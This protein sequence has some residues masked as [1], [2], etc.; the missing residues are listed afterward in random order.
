M[1]STGAR[2]FFLAF[3]LFL[4]A[5]GCVQDA[6]T[7]STDNGGGDTST[8]GDTKSTAAT[9]DSANNPDEILIDGSSTVWPISSAVAEAFMEEHDD[10]VVQV[11]APS[12]TSGGFKK[13]MVGEIDIND[14]SRPIKD[15]EIEKC[16]QQGIETLE[17]TIAI[18]GLSVVVNKDNTWCD[19]LTFA[20]LKALW[21]PNSKVKTWK[22]LNSE[23]PADEI[24]LFGPDGDS[25]TFEYFTEKVVELKKQCRN[26]YEPATDDN[27]LVKGVSGDKNALGYFGY[28]YYLENRDVLKGLSIVGKD[29]GDAVAPTPK[30][31]ESYAY[32]LAR[33][34]FI[35][36][37][38][39]R[40]SDKGMKEFLQFYVGEEGQSYVPRAGYIEVADDVKQKNVAALEAAL[41]E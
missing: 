10:F 6:D 21:E 14:A 34:I 7:S 12:G 9:G 31:I 36:V 40:L 2:L 20:Q 30:T 41:A 15:S 29:G 1:S 8:S 3:G 39:S 4:A 33:P 25:G 32:P 16:A 5:P 13:F 26:D 17:L 27:I 35:Y 22:D 23:W 28:A 38:K 18:D 37:N 19:S 24:K 11:R